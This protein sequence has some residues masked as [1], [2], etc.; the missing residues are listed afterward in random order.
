ML[1]SKEISAYQRFTGTIQWLEC[2]TRPDNLQTVA[3]LS[4]HNIK[5]TDRCWAAVTR[6]LW[7]L[8]SNRTR[9]IC[10]GNSNHIPYRY[11]NSSWVDDLYNRR[12]TARYVF[13][14]NGGPISWSSRRQST[15]STS[16]CKAEYIAKA[17]RVFGALW[18]R[19]LLSELGILDTTL[20]DGY[21]K[22][23]SPPTII[24]A[25]NQG[26]IKLTENPEYHRK[27]K[28]ISIK[29]HKT[30]GLVQDGVVWFE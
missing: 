21:P 8:K 25:D 24:F 27:T 19:S 17:D 4:Q 23:V 30:R 7:Y 18:L 29:Y 9:S 16:T 20:E 28:H 10:Y 11:S 15:V 3:K 14:L 5:P 26:A 13:I 6:L 2:Q 12:S 22:T 1:N